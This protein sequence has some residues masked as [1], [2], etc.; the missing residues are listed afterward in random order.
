MFDPRR[1]ALV[2]LLA[3]LAAC[4]AG[5]PPAAPRALPGE[6]PSRVAEAQVG[7]A[8]ARPEIP[9]DA[10]LVVFLGDSIAAGLHLS[11]LDAFPAVL[12]R[13]LAAAG[14]PF[15]LVNAGTSGDTT[16]GGLRRVDWILK[17]RPDVL[18]VELGGNDGLRG[19]DLAA[20][21]SNL[22]AIASK[23]RAAGARVVLLGVRIPESYGAD[24]AGAFRAIYPRVATELEL[25]FVP[26]FMDGVGGVPDMNLEDGLHPTA[27]GHARIAQ[28]V[29]PVLSAVL[30]ALPPREAR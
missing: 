5:S 10:P 20:V 27:A 12:Q 28:N 16:A 6:A 18:V 26:E 29:A 22:R 1:P 7:E 25:D 30:A 4:G 13:E 9:A 3:A 15:R 14:R 24:Y 2:I 11:P 21:E 19:Q 23:G 8:A 17:Q